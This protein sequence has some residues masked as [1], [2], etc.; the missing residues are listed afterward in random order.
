MRLLRLADPAGSRQ[1]RQR[2]LKRRAYKSK[3][4]LVAIAYAG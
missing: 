4:S 2:R 1:R 3:V